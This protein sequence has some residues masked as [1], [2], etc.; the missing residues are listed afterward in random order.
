MNKTIFKKLFYSSVLSN[1][2]VHSTMYR[3]RHKSRYTFV[4][5]C[6]FVIFG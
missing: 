5:G 4:K 2:A 3:V 6:R 1:G